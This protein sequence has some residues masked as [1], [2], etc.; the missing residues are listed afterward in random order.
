MALFGS[1][2]RAF[3]DAE[4]AWVERMMDEVY[5][6]FV[7]RVAD[8]RSLSP[9]RVDELGRGR[10]WSGA[11]ALAHGL[12]DELGDLDAGITVARRLAG[13][14]D[15]APVRALTAGFTL[16]GV[17]VPGREA[18]AGVG[19]AGVA[20]AVTTALLASVWP[21]GEEPVLTWFDAAVTIR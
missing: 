16:P 14:P 2:N 9:E 17:P 6:R 5:A 20:G 18:A 11:D 4:R 8:G 21:F 12:V 7:A 13:L 10:I 15:D 19:A 1:P 3:S